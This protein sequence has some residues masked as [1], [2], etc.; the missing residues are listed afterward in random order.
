MCA[1]K[2]TIKYFPIILFSA[3]LFF[4][5]FPA[6]ANAGL[7]MI[8]IFWPLLFILFLPI[9]MIE[10]GV[11]KKYTRSFSPTPRLFW[12]LVMANL[13]STLI[14]IPLTWIALVGMEVG[15]SLFLPSGTVN[16]SYIW[17]LT[18]PWLYPDTL[19]HNWMI[20]TAL[21]I[22]LIPFYFISAWTEGRIMGWMT[23]NK[24]HKPH[25]RNAMW[26]ANFFSYLFLV[27]FLAPW[28]FLK[29]PPVFISFSNKMAQIFFLKLFF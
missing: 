16:L 15:V 13:F 26:K 18:A 2:D 9:V 24:E 6:S 19:Q 20:V 1:L 27:L 14:G 25:I 21:L 10:Y 7:P 5:P 17:P 3:L 28:L 11:M 29:P 12:P 23:K 8:I 22:L 4:F